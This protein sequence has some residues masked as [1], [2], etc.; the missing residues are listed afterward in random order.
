MKQSK[1]VGRPPKY[2]TKEEIQKKIDDYFE[3]CKGEVLR[4]EDGKIVYN[5][6]GNPVLINVYPPTIS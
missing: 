4:D 1:A 3:K 2:K 6:W 5:K